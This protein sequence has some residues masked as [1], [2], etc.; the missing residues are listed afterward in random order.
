MKTSTEF[1][2][3]APNLNRFAHAIFVLLLISA[4]AISLVVSADGELVAGNY[5]T[6]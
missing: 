4:V 1:T 3:T 5:R 6:P 2:K